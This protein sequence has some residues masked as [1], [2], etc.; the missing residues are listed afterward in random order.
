MRLHYCS[1]NNAT[2]FEEQFVLA[3]DFA[4]TKQA[5]GAIKEQFKQRRGVSQ[6]LHFWGDYLV[7]I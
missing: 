2:H 5:K 1:F 7:F 6:R 3:G 4:N